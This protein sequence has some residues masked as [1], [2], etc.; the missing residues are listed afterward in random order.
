MHFTNFFTNL[1]NTNFS[2][3]T[4]KINISIPSLNLIL[5]IIPFL[6][7][8]SSFFFFF[9]FLIHSTLHRF[10]LFL[11][12]SSFLSCMF[13]ISLTF[14]LSPTTIAFLLLFFPPTPL[15]LNRE[16]PP[17][18]FLSLFSQ[19]YKPRV[20]TLSFSRMHAYHECGVAPRIVPILQQLR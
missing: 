4:N 6:D 11:S 13:T 2:R 12:S 3:L 17:H 1:E 14:S 18:A 8:P 16:N 5:S 9:F 15:L 20:S 10:H 19:V 7:F